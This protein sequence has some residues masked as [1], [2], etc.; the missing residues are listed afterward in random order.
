[1][2]LS[3]ADI[4][5]DAKHVYVI[6]N[7][8][9]DI[10]I[11][12]RDDDG[13]NRLLRILRASIPQDA[14][15]MVSPAML[16]RTANFKRALSNGYLTLIPEQEAQRLLASSDAKLELASIKKKLSRIPPELMVEHQDTTPLE[17]ISGGATDENIRAEVKD[18]AVDED[19]SADDKL[20]RLLTIHNEEALSSNEITWLLSRLPS[21]GNEYNEI[22]TWL[23]RKA[24]EAD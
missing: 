9:T 8:K 2:S 1:M 21:K 14:A 3:I 4:K 16:K 18:I 5:K 12:V 7:T 10:S 20:A 22:T 23:Q 17:A 19:E 24:R 6:N 15:E 11:T 13:V